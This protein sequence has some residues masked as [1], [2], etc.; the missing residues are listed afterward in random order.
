MRLLRGEKKKKRVQL[1][2]KGGGCE[3]SYD[4]AG[5]IEVTEGKENVEKVKENKWNKR[6]KIV[7]R[8]S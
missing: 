3:A 8:F 7:L 6:R 2:D 1:Y 5:F 4:E